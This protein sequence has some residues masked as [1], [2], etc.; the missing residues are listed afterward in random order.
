[1]SMEAAGIVDALVA[2]GVRKVFGMG[3]ERVRPIERALVRTGSATWVAVPDPTAG[4]V[5]ASIEACLTSRATACVVVCDPSDARF[6]RTLDDCRAYRCPLVVLVVPPATTEP[7]L[8]GRDVQVRVTIAIRRALEH[9]DVAL[10]VLRDARPGSS[11]GDAVPDEPIRTLAG[12]L[13]AA[14]RIAILCGA[15]CAGAHPR[16]VTLANKLKAP[17]AHSLEGKDQVEYHNPFDVGVVGPVGTLSAAYALAECDVLLMLGVDFPHRRFYPW[18]AGVVV[19]Q[20]DVRP[21]QI[22]RYAP[23]TI[24]IVGDVGAVLAALLPLLEYKDD[25]TFLDLAVR[26]HRDAKAWSRSAADLATG[27]IRPW[28]L[29]RSIHER[30]AADPLFTWDLGAP[31]LWVA[32][33]LHMN[34]KRRMLG[35][36]SREQS[37]DAVRRATAAQ[38]SDPTRQVVALAGRASA[39]ALATSRETLGRGDLRIKVFLFDD[40]PPN[41]VDLPSSDR[42]EPTAFDVGDLAPRARP[43]GTLVLGLTAPSQVERVVAA[44]LAHDGPVLVDARTSSTPFRSARPNRRPVQQSEALDHPWVVDHRFDHLVDW[45]AGEPWAEH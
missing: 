45:R 7:L 8:D 5:G 37:V 35:T 23:A 10:V 4:A 15:G 17:V 40:R 6:E 20:V 26:H 41:I 29:A 44:A 38:L 21:E 12:A 2:S 33:C 32:R 19:G 11:A 25:G 43:P 31:M 39:G 42:C 30:A 22:G 36:F 34:G 28:H 18:R 16:L 13:N 24:G 9:R 27:P 3:D 1:M 14:G